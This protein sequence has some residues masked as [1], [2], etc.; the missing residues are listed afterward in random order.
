MSREPSMLLAR[1]GS[2]DVLRLPGGRF[3]EGK[4]W[5]V[6]EVGALPGHHMAFTC[7]CFILIC[8]TRPSEVGSTRAVMRSLS[9][10]GKRVTARR[11]SGTHAEDEAERWPL[12]REEPSVIVDLGC[13]LEITEAD[14]ECARDRLPASD[15]GEPCADEEWLRGR[16]RRSLLASTTF[17]LL[18]RKAFSS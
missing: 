17:T 10:T 8:G 1:P 7:S 15:K 4:H 13:L 12:E 11:C 2:E 6:L 16:R 5:R 14:E 9:A 3:L 18:R